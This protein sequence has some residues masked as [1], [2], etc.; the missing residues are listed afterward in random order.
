MS[1]TPG[2]QRF[3]AEVTRRRVFRVMAVYGA[4]GFVVLQVADLLAEGLGL[5]EVVLRTATFLVLIGFPIAL[6]LAWA[7]ELSPEGLQRE[8]PREEVSAEAGHGGAG[9]ADGGAAA[10]PSNGWRTPTPA[11]GS[12]PMRR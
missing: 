9:T 4:T 5:P 1:D 8:K 6:V 2:Y 10:L 12:I 3:F 7:F 11:C